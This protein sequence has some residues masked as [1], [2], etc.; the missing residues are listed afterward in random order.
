MDETYL[1][2][3]LSLINLSPDAIRKHGAMKIVYTP[4]HG[5]GVRLV[6]EA[7]KQVGFTQVL[8][9]PEQDVTDGNFHRCFA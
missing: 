1:K 4:L 5:T 7:M 3:I 2:A 9:V 6:P 8:H